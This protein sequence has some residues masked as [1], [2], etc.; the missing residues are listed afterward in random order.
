[1]KLYKRI[2]GAIF[3]ITLLFNIYQIFIGVSLISQPDTGY[4]IGGVFGLIVSS[5][6]SFWLISSTL[7]EIK[8][9]GQGYWF[10]KSIAI[11][12]MIILLIL[13]FY[14]FYIN[15]G[16]VDLIY[17]L[18]AVIIMLAFYLPIVIYD[19]KLISKSRELR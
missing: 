10:M 9:R 17:D 4:R 6:Y 8:Y 11:I 3:I 19:L 13:M 18:F 12:D 14:S 16:H 1:V 5:T 15:I 2:I 7:N